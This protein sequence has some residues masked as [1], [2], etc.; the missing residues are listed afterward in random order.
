MPWLIFDEREYEQLRT[1]LL[2]LPIQ[3]PRTYMWHSDIL[4]S[5]ISTV[6][7][8]NFVPV[9]RI[10]NELMRLKESVVADTF[11]EQLIASGSPHEQED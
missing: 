1:A 3:H 11:R 8:G 9:I 7:T 10:S 4:L 2:Q 6:N 5:R